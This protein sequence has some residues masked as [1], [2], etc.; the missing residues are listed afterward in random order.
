MFTGAFAADMSVIM[1]AVLMVVVVIW[2][3]CWLQ[4]RRQG[5]II[6]FL[7]SLSM[8]LHT[9]ADIGKDVLYSVDVGHNTGFFWL[10][11][12]ISAITYGYITWLIITNRFI[13]RR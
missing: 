6:V 5:A 3:A 13:E 10:S 1:L 9:M 8:L 7:L 11:A 12:V 2:F 4:S